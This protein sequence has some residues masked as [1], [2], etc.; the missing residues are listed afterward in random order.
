MKEI[1]KA[2]T[3]LRNFVFGFLTVMLIAV[4]LSV[5]SSVA[6]AQQEAGVMMCGWTSKATFN[7]I[8]ITDADDTW[9]LAEN[10]Y[11]VYGFNKLPAIPQGDAC[12]CIKVDR[13]FRTRRIIQVY[14]GK[15]IPIKKCQQDPALN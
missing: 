3:A 13:D 4:S 1:K 11:K 15:M 10:S 7:D 6:H 12:A 2:F 8:T 9:V 14:G 5:F